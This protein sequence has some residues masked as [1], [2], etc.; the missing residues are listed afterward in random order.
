MERT[1]DT[2]RRETGMKIKYRK[3]NNHLLNVAPSA[4]LYPRDPLWNNHRLVVLIMF[5]D[6]LQ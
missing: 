2:N 1:Y 3:K 5:P 6:E 4:L